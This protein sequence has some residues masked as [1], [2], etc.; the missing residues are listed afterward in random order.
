MHL[1]LKKEQISASRIRKLVFLLKSYFSDRI[2]FV[3]ITNSFWFI[4]SC[5]LPFISIKVFKY[6]TFTFTKPAETLSCLISSLLVF[7]SHL[8]SSIIFVSSFPFSSP[9]TFHLF[10]S[11]LLS[12]LLYSNLLWFTPF[13]FPFFSSSHHVSLCLFSLSSFVISPVLISSLFSNFSPL[14]I[15]ISISLLKHMLLGVK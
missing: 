9:Y 7:S 15:V 2:V 3:L 8:V 12:Y 5:P 1:C 4:S 13:L 11:L 6:L 10:L 14:F